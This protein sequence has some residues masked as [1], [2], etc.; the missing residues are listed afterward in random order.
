[1]QKEH[2]QRLVG[3]GDHTDFLVASSMSSLILAQLAESPELADV[4]QELLSNEGNELY[5]KNV[6]QMH[7]EGKHTIRELRLIMLKRGYILL[8]DLDSEKYCTFTR[9][10]N[11]EVVLSAEDCLIV[12]GEN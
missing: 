11:D 1:M 6:R 8:G 10:L 2:N 3:R 5:L 7:L 9:K 4:F 12:I